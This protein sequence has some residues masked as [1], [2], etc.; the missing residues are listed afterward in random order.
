MIT[1]SAHRDLSSG[2]IVALRVEGH[3]EDE[4]ACAAVS[5]LAFLMKEVSKDAIVSP[6]LSE[7]TV[8]AD[9]FSQTRAELLTQGFL[10]LYESEYKIEFLVN[11]ESIAA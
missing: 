5:M 4:R 7:C 8:G 3:S 9:S 2:K 6:G 11:W 10:C 1:F